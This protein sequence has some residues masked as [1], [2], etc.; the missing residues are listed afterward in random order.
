M[1]SPPF[2][3]AVFI[4]NAF[5]VVS[6]SFLA[7]SGWEVVSTLWNTYVSPLVDEDFKE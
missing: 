1:E 4:F 5:G 7:A 3:T 2:D 6:L